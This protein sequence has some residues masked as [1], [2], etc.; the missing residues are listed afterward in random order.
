MNISDYILEFL[1]QYDKVVVNN[2]GVFSFENSKAEINT[3]E[4]VIL[5]PAKRVVFQ[6]NK[7]I[8]D[9]IFL[10][11]LAQKKGISLE[12]AKFELQTQVDFWQKKI[13]AKDEFS[14]SQLGNFIKEDHQLIFKGKRI[15]KESPDFFGLEKINYN[16]LPKSTTDSA[17]ASASEE[18][19]IT[20]YVFWIFLVIIP[21]IGLAY[22]A[23]TYQDILLGKK[24]SKNITIKTSTH[25]I[26]DKKQSV[27]IDSLATDSLSIEKE[28]LPQVVNP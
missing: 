25:R 24:D 11:F 22:L 4:K 8:E 9:K 12:N 15:E 20:Q 23:Y 2:F 21:V 27:K 5:P 13:N 6:A 1:K 16:K 26:E 7:G 28:E 17:K 14:I 18:H 10:N 3:N 19:P